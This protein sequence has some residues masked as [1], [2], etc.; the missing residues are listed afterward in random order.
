MR[1]FAGA[2]LENILIVGS[3]H[4]WIFTRRGVLYNAL[5]IDDERPISG[6]EFP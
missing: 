1:R 3:D 2:A 4:E 5:V 6:V